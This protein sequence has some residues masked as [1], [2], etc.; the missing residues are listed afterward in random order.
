MPRKG[1]YCCR[2]GGTGWTRSGNFVCFEHRLASHQPSLAQPRCP[3]CR[4]PMFYLGPIHELPKKRDD[5]GW[6]RLKA[7]TVR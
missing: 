5:K 4:K 7:L 6:Q 1:C 3:L 2:Q